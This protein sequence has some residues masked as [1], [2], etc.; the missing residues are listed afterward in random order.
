MRRL[1]ATQLGMALL[2][3]FGAWV[4]FNAAYAKATLFGAALAIING[5]LL[6]RSVNRAGDAVLESLRGKPRAGMAVL[7]SGF[8][9]RLIVV[10]LGMLTGIQ[11]LGLHPAPMIFGLGLTQFAVVLGRPTS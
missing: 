4:L 9:Q 7:M 1:L 3:A 8:M 11:V 6:A 5:Q 10:L 2:L